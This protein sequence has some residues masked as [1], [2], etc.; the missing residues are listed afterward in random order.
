MDS[1]KRM[2]EGLSYIEQRLAEEIDMSEAARLACCSEY[3]FTRMFSFLAGVPLSEY[4]RRRRL[5]LAAFELQAGNAKVIEVAIRYGYT[6]P[7]YRSE[8]WIP[9]KKRA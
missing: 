7:D 5:T 6:S 4:V 1:L 8:I 3:H 9:V 2:N